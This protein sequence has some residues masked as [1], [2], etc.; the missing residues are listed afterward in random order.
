MKTMRER[1]QWARGVSGLSARGLAKR[2]DIALRLVSLIEAGDRDN[3]ELKTVQ[4]VADALGVPVGWLAS[5]EGERPAAESIRAAVGA[6]DD[7]G[8]EHAEP[9]A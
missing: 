3:P 7:D 6:I 4:R 9:A 1:L 8:D 5:G 2:A